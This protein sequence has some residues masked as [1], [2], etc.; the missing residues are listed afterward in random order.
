MSGVHMPW[1]EDVVFLTDGGIETD[2]I[3]NKGAELPLFAAFTLLESSEGRELLKRYYREYTPIAAEVGAGFVFESPTW[4]ANRDWAVKLG[5]DRDR[6]A[7]ANVTAMRLLQELRSEF[8]DPTKSVLSGCVGPRGDGYQVGE[9]MSASEAHAY[10][11]E[12]VDMLASGGAEMISA[13]TMTYVNEAVGV[14][15]AARSAGLPVAL[16]FT[17]E[18]DGLLPDGTPLGKAVVE[19]DEATSGCSSYFMINCAHPTHFLPVL[20]PEFGWVERIRGVRANASRL[21]HAELDEAA[22]L[23]CGDPQEFGQLYQA[24]RKTF[25]N[26]TVLGG[27]CGTDARHIRAA[28]HAAAS[29]RF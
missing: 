21:S 20:S 2:L 6:L 7:L 29:A 15:R 4:R 27:C 13:I 1:V 26:V 24:L 22:E 8:Y 3:F 23:D 11:Q 5:Y 19:T 12:Q 18:T 17:V 9:T 14:A 10:H 16:S 28:A 25:P